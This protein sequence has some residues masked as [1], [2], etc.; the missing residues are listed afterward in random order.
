LAFAYPVRDEEEVREKLTILNKNFHDATHHCYA[1]VLGREGEEFR[2]NDD[3]EPGHSAGTPILGQ[4]RSNNLTNVLVVVVRYFG[5]TKLGV[6][7]LVAAYKKAAAEALSA[8]EIITEIVTKKVTFQFDYMDM[9]EVMHLIKDRELKVIQQQ[10]EISCYMT[11]AIRE[12]SY[13][14]VIEKLEQIPSL[15]LR[16]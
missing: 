11:L 1:Y 2:A 9:K 15:T 7:G 14:E 10:F 12:T 16:D 6:G 13:K 8:N 3:G 4:I 5:G